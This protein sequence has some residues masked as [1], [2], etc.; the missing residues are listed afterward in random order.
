MDKKLELRIIASGKAK[1]PTHVDMVIMRSTAGDIGILPG[2]APVSMTL[3]TGIL[4]V[5]DGNNEEHMSVMG[6][7]ASV[8]NNIITIMTRFI[9][10]HKITD[11]NISYI[12][13]QEEEIT[14]EIEAIVARIAKLEHVIEICNLF[15]QDYLLVNAEQFREVLGWTAERW[16]RVNSMHEETRYSELRDSLSDRMAAY[17]DKPS[18]NS[19][20]NSIEHLERHIVELKKKNMRLQEWLDGPVAT[21]R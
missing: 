4:R 5:I 20:N 8:A 11:E 18:Q 21:Q 17:A 16:N 1:P 7:V 6:G 15:Q 2:R 3:N 12:N 10:E 13:Q 9:V 14:A 19:L